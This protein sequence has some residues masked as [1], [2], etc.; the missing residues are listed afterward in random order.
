VTAAD[1]SLLRLF[2]VIDDKRGEERGLKL[3]LDA[4]FL[5]LVD[6]SQTDWSDRSVGRS[7]RSIVVF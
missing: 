4:Q 5:P 2:L 7:D 3:D 6:L 1:G